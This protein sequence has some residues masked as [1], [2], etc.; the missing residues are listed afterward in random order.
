MIAD[1]RYVDN[2]E[3]VRELAARLGTRPRVA[4]DTEG[5]SLF[6]YF[7]RV[8]LIQLSFEGE[9]YLVDTLA[10]LY[11]APLYDALAQCPL[12]LHAADNDFRMLYTEAGFAPKAG[13]FDTLIAAQLLGR[14]QLSL[15]ALVESCAGV[16]LCKKGQK[17]NWAQRPLTAEQ[18]AYAVDDTKY[19]SRIAQEQQYELESLGRLDWH[20]EACAR[21]AETGSKANGRDPEEAWRIRGSGKLRRKELAYLREVWRWRDEEA[22]AVDKPPFKILGNDELTNLA[23]WAV[24]NPDQGLNTGPRLPKHCIGPRLAALKGALNHARELPREEWP[25]PRPRVLNGPPLPSFQEDVEK[26]KETSR[27]IGGELGIEPS[28]VAPRAALEAI[29]RK[30]PN[31]LEALIECSGLM[32]W[33]IGLLRGDVLAMYNGKASNHV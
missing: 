30:R 19:L 6:N 27:R 25:E 29:A 15:A 24:H 1:Y 32:N 7:E 28:V 33:Q 12:I 11:L 4:L 26:L 31:C 22:R 20:R 16:T 9:H 13:V 3:A 17:S 21:S 8:C 14:E 18:L 23:L 2:A 10:R 5:N